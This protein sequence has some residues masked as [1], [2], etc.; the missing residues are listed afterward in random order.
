MILSRVLLDENIG[1]I[2]A[3]RLRELG[4]E[5]TSILEASPGADD[6]SVLARALK[7]DSIFV[8]LDRDFGRL[9]FL[10]S[11]NHAG[12]IYIRLRKESPAN[13]MDVLLSLFEEYGEKL[14]GKF[15]TVTD[16]VVR[17]R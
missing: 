2:V 8:T 9:V 3:V 4:Y 13:T 7:E 11:R 6:E 10:E 5:V 16:G 12:I 1:A 15:T 17:M 14:K